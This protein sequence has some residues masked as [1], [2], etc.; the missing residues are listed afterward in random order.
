MGPILVNMHCG[1]MDVPSVVQAHSPMQRGIRVRRMRICAKRSLVIFQGKKRGADLRYGK[2]VLRELFIRSNIKKFPKLLLLGEKNL[3][4]RMAKVISRFRIANTLLSIS[5]EVVVGCEAV[6][7][8]SVEH[9]QREYA[10]KRFRHRRI[11]LEH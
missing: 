1:D 10:F 6:M 2:L 7:L 9:F 5:G 11:G 8:A 4:N 3:Y